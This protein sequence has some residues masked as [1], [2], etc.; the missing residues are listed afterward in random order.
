MGYN[1]EV[2]INLLEHT[3]ISEIK[4]EI[5]DY[6]LDY[7]CNHYYYLYEMEGGCKFPR[8]H[9]VMVINFD[10]TEIFNCGKFVSLLK[11][12]NNLHIECIYED[13]T[14]CKLIYAS[15]YYQTTMNKNNVIK[16]NKFKRER[17]LSEN[18]KIILD[19]KDD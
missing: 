19:I 8:N 16:Y 4:K 18:E 1:I 11:K 14:I 13:D 9:C 6:A 7:E 3:N 10:D 12:K 5:A 15:K 17:N 2:S